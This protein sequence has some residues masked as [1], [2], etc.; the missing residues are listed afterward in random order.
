MATYDLEEQDTIEDL[1][2]WWTRWGTLVTWIAV[3][4]AVTIVGV[5]GW[6][7]WQTSRADEASALYQAVAGATRGS[8]DATKAKDAMATLADKYAGTAYAPRAAL[9]YAKQLWSTG[10]KAGAKAQLQWVVDRASD[11]D[12]KAVARYRLAEVLLDEKNVDEAL[13]LLDTKH[14]DAYAGLYADLRGDA[15]A[16][17]GRNA[18]ARAAYQSAFAKLDARSPYRGFVQLKLDALGGA[19]PVGTEADALAK[20]ASAAPAAAE[21][22]P[23][24]PAAAGAPAAKP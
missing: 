15:L 13:K 3:A 12:L 10:D 24:T 4:V 23:A 2:A 19:L 22:P 16:S 9:L 6:R 1:K 20:A 21:A 8:G 7:W 17:A 11:D 14:A 5:Q 18:E